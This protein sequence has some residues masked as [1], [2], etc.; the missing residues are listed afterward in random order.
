MSETHGSDANIFRVNRNFVLAERFGGAFAALPGARHMAKKPV[1]TTTTEAPPRREYHRTDKG[2]DLLP[3]PG[4]KR[5]IA[6]D[7]LVAN[8]GKPLEE[9][10]AAINAAKAG[11][12]TGRN[13]LGWAR[14]AGL[15]EIA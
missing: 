9:A 13:L 3:R 6:W 12:I 8:E 11:A 10:V 2:K 4:S 1:A 7:L 5:A 15:I 14:K